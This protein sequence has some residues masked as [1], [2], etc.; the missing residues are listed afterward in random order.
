MHF[1]PSYPLTTTGCWGLGENTTLLT[2]AGL[3]L[4]QQFGEPGRVRLGLHLQ[5]TDD[6]VLGK[7]IKFLL[8]AG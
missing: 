2:D 3:L 1:R 7:G 5:I 4:L 6:R 8:L